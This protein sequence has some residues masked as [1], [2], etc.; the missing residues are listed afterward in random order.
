MYK[1]EELGGLQRWV[2]QLDGAKAVMQIPALGYAGGLFPEYRSAQTGATPVH[3]AVLDL[4]AVLCQVIEARDPDTGGH[5]NRVAHYA[6]GMAQV[7]SWTPTQLATLKMGAQLHD[8]GKIGIADSLLNKP[9]R[10]SASEYQQMQLHVTLGLQILAGVPVL[11]PVLPYVAYHHERYDGTGY[12][13]GLAG[14][15]IPVEGRLLAVAD[16]FDAMT[17][18][19]PYQAARTPAEGLA[20][21]HRQA[22][23][24]FDP[25]MVVAFETAYTTGLIDPH[26]ENAV[27]LR[28]ITH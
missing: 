12:P 21:L 1:W 5:S 20:E 17:S 7:L 15:A 27:V 2:T 4:V 22:G 10:L 23:K 26:S 28:R 16:S 6:Q 14:A 19:R 9:G 3:R 8:I 11:E 13:F 18:A 24:Q 25:A